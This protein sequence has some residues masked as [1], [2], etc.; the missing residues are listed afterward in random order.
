MARDTQS[1]IVV[2]GA[3]PLSIARANSGLKTSIS[4]LFPLRWVPIVDKVLP[5]G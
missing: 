3:D 5:I 1:A 4:S 2:G